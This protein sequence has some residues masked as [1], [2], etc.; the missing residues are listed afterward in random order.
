[1][2]DETFGS[3]T[4]IDML[5]DNGNIVNPSLL[6]TTM[7]V[8]S[9]PSKV[10]QLGFSIHMTSAPA[11]LVSLRNALVKAQDNFSFRFRNGIVETNFNIP[12]VFYEYYLV[13]LMASGIVD[14]NDINAFDEQVA[15]QFLYDYVGFVFEDGFTMNSIENTFAKVGK[16]VDLSQYASLFNTLKSMINAGG[17]VTVNGDGYTV[18]IVVD[19][20]YVKN[21][22]DKLGQATFSSLIKEAKE[23]ES[24]VINLSAAVDDFG[25]EYDAIV[26]EKAALSQSGVMNKLE[27]LDL[28]EDLVQKVNELNG[29]SVIVLE[30]NIGSAQNPVELVFNN[31]TVIDLNGYNIYGTVIGNGE[32]VVVMDSQVGAQGNGIVGSV[33]GNVTLTAGTYAFNAA[34]FLP[35]GY[36]QNAEGAVTNEFFTVVADANGNLTYQFNANILSGEIVP[37]AKTILY[38]IGELALDRAVNYYNTAAFG[39]DHH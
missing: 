25:A 1:M 13:A 17:G 4:I 9:D 10:T 26:L 24:I 38:I 15:Y 30:K 39:L 11:Q 2:A 29:F 19:D 7:Q 32:K 6:S 20:A 34:G 23:G 31:K 27:V 36:V 18:S 14:K 21:A 28:T 33:A 22:M 12:E 35:E 5:D 16:D 8:G 37:S 3:Q